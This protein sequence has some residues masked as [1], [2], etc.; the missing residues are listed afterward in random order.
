MDVFAVSCYY[1]N[2]SLQILQ[3]RTQATITAERFSCPEFNQRDRISSF[4][5]LILTVYFGFHT[6]VINEVK[7]ETH[8]S[9]NPFYSQDN[10]S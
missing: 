10:R 1:K 7:H 3:V 4:P 8:R 5:A 6:V 9:K 2:T